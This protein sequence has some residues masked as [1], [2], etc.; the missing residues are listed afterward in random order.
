MNTVHQIAIVVKYLPPSYTK[1]S[2]IKLILPR[3][4]NKSITFSYHM[5]DLE[6]NN[7]HEMA[8]CFLKLHDITPIGLLDMGGFYVL[9]VDFKD[10]DSV[11]QLFKIIPQSQ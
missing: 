6:G 2:R 8:E 7:T 5:E 9:S 11:K 3:W 10:M 4:E 1:P